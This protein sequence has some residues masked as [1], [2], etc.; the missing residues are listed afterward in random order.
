MSWLSELA[1]RHMAKE[2]RESVQERLLRYRREIC[3]TNLERV[4]RITQL[5]DD[6]ARAMLLIHSLTEACLTKGVFSRE[7]LAAAIRDIDMFDG[8]ADGKLDPAVVRP[9]KATHNDSASGTGNDG[10]GSQ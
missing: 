4:D 1:K 7:E 10:L 5:E 2:E 6:L 8:V 9:S 3:D